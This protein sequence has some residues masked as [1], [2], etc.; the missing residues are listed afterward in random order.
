MNIKIVGMKYL[1]FASASARLW[2]Y[3]KIDTFAPKFAPPVSTHH[4]QTFIQKSRVLQKLEI[5]LVG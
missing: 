1:N 4:V 2:T 5:N 3:F